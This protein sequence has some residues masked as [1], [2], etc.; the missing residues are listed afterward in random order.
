MHDLEATLTEMRER[1]RATILAALKYW[2][3]EGRR[4]SPGDLAIAQLAGPELSGYELDQ[5]IE[6]VEAAR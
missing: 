3:R 1:Q 2:K 6:C 4:A 5:L